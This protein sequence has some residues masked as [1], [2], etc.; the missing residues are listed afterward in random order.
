MGAFNVVPAY[1]GNWTVEAVRDLPYS[2][3]EQAGAERYQGKTESSAEGFPYSWYAYY[4]RPNSQPS[5]IYP[6]YKGEFPYHDYRLWN[7]REGVLW[8]INVSAEP[9]GGKGLASA[10]GSVKLVLRYDPDRDQNYQINL[11]DKPKKPIYIKVKVSPHVSA[12]DGTG[13]GQSHDYAKAH[14]K[15]SAE[16]LGEIVGNLNSVSEKTAYGHKSKEGNHTFYIKFDPKDGGVTDAQDGSIR[17]TV[18]LVNITEAEAKLDGDRKTDH[19]VDHPDYRYE[20]NKGRVEAEVV[21]EGELAYFG[22]RSNL[23][24]SFYKE[25]DAAKL[26]KSKV[27]DENGNV[28]EVVDTNKVRWSDPKGKA[29]SVQIEPGSNRAESAATRRHP[30]GKP[31]SWYGEVVFTASQQTL[32]YPT[33]TWEKPEGAVNSYDY[34]FWPYTSSTLDLA[35]KWGSSEIEQGIA[36][37]GDKAGVGMKQSSVAK[38]T[39]K[40]DVVSLEESY[41]V[42]WHLPAD[43]W[44]SPPGSGET[45]TPHRESLNSTTIDVPSSFDF[46]NLGAGEPNPPHM[47]EFD[48]G[49]TASVTGTLV[50]AAE[51][52]WI[53]GTGATLAPPVGATLMLASAGI[54]IAGNLADSGQPERKTY[55]V[56]DVASYSA[57]KQA[58]MDAE[59]GITYPDGTVKFSPPERIADAKASFKSQMFTD[60]DNSGDDDNF[61]RYNVVVSGE[62][63]FDRIRNIYDCDE[64]DRNG[65]AGRN[66]GR[67]T[68]WASPYY[69]VT[70][71]T[72]N[73]PGGGSVTPG[74]GISPN[75][76]TGGGG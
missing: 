49:T 48:W 12:G 53:V 27:V 34:S 71:T 74:G 67:I 22:L 5:E 72:V 54:S 25:T 1:A 47:S 36:L 57:Y 37:G 68:A 59:A 40:D 43:K 63:L 62:A 21:V 41:T 30:L 45:L 23:E 69:R 50:G 52:A 2:Q 56:P 73:Q 11:D 13:D 26:P 61:A 33:F 55:S 42:N 64:W 60:N 29:F 39:V 46:Y 7:G 17:Y 19:S 28:S 76:T 65:Y 31:E 14:V 24:P 9:H 20:W 18:P 6:P 38:V 70:F 35:F 58:V 51:A 15:F 32:N 8:H 4:D 16:P 75:G 10:K 44:E 3:Q 66:R